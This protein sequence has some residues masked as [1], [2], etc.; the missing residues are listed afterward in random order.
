MKETCRCRK[1]LF[2]TQ[3]GHVGVYVFTY[4][5]SF[6]YMFAHFLCVCYISI[7]SL[8]ILHGDII[9][10]SQWERSKHLITLLARELPAVGSCVIRIC[11]EDEALT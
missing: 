4:D 7:K 6:R 10:T 5:N 11:L 3:G 9:F 1:C 8:K 2:L